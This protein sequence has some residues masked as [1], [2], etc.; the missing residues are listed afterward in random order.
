MVQ[1]KKEEKVIID[2]LRPTAE[3]APPE[4][5][6]SMQ[7]KVHLADLC[8]DI[9]REEGVD[10][11][12]YLTGGNTDAVVAR[13]QRAGIKAVQVRHEQSAGFAL[14]AVGRLTCRPGFAVAGKGTG[15]TNFST[16]I[17]QAYSAGAPGV[18]IQMESGTVDDDKY[19][20]QGVARTENQLQGI[21]KWARRVTN[22]KNVLFQLK[23]AFRSAMTPPTGPVVVGLSSDEF[24]PQTMWVPRQV[25]LANYTPGYWKPNPSA[26]ETRA[27]PAVVEQAVRWL[28]EAQKPTIIAGHAAHQDGCQDEL[29]E[30]AHLLG[31]PCGARRIARG[32]ISELDPLNYGR[33]ARGPVFRETD[34]CLVL[35]LRIGFLEAWGRAPFF[36][37]TARYCQIQSDPGTV[38]LVLPTEIEIVANLK[39]TLRQMIECAKDLGVTKP[40]AK[41]EKWRQFVV[42]TET[43]YQ[44]RVLARTAQ[45]EHQ[46]PLH[47]DIVGRYAAEVLSEDYNND[48]ITII[49]GFTAS[50]YFTAWN[51]AVNTGT[52][53]DA[54]ETIGI[55]H[56]PAMA[57]GAGI[58][59]K[60]TKPILALMGDGAVGA[61][62]MDIETCVRWDIPVVFLHENNN[63]LI[64]GRWELFFSKACAVTGDILKDSWQTVPNIHYERM[65]AE[66]GC[67]PEFVE[68]PE[69]VKPALK[70]AFAFAMREKKPAFVEAF[71]DMEVLHSIT[72]N[73]AMVLRVATLLDWEEVAEPGKKLVATQLATPTIL[74][75]LPESW[76]KGI[77][78]YKK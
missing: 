10:H 15:L 69:E 26:W 40:L 7:E 75:M 61:G 73:P 12:Y 53:L 77:A 59:T 64:N 71:V 4:V 3:M 11:L 45:M 22:P 54:S 56:S 35:G 23:R 74:P 66:V 5:D 42:D 6:A 28:L 55:G 25:A 29:R 21:T 41:W 62:G 24:L 8:V 58:V 2:R 63:T 70:R 27:N 57:L 38:D 18:A 47:P 72:A 20:S 31:V 30:F 36:P 60:G 67:H 37:H 14:D 48:Y 33:R 76:K 78:E 16:G 52:V 17:C 44:K 49:D 43:S 13:M 9:L 34:R 19:G 50:A 68:R 1:E 39:Q 32:M 46:T 65:F 51:V